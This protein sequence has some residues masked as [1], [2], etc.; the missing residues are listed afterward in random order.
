MLSPLAMAS[1]R[2]L[3]TTTPHPSPRAKPLADASKVLKRPS[4][5]T[6]LVIDKKT[7]ISG[8]I[9]RC[10][11]PARARSDSPFR[12]D[13]QAR[14]TATREDEQAVSTAILGPCRPRIYDNLPGATQKRFP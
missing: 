6:A 1:V 5:A 8:E 12:R 9:I 3:S 14:C 2:R 7:L 13:V 11:P 4:G 10:E